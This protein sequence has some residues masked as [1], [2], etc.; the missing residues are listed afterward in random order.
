MRPDIDVD[1]VASWIIHL[2]FLLTRGQFTV[3]ISSYTLIL[4]IGTI[5]LQ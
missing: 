4:T 5:V 2:P 1:E 3:P